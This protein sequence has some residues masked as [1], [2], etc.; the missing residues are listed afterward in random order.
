MFGTEPNPKFN[1][2]T[3]LSTRI[4]PNYFKMAAPLFDK[5]YR[6]QAMEK[7][8]RLEIPLEK[9]RLIYP[10]TPDLILADPAGDNYIVDH[11]FIYNFYTDD[12]INLLPQVPKYI[13]A[14][15]ALGL[16]VKGGMY[17][18]LR[19]RAVKDQGLDAN[20]RRV[21]FVP[22]NA[23]IRQAFT[24]QVKIMNKIA[25]YKEGKLADW[26]SNVT[27]TQNSMI[28]KSCSFKPLCIVEIN[29]GDG[30]L[31]R[32]VEYNPNSYGYSEDDD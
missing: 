20:F 29:G 4:L 11:K 30:I 2:L 14:L 13:G 5:G 3:D 15:R 9:R 24:Q 19:W 26:K 6:V 18:M 23:R 17:N 21:P 7:T 25:D 27:R 22:S 32:K 1:I 31:M 12:E 16:P 8:F 28:C 10:F